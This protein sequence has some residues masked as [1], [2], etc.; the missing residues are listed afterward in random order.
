M[1]LASVMTEL[2]PLITQLDPVGLSKILHELG[3][4]K[5]RGGRDQ[6]ARQN[7][8]LHGFRSLGFLHYLYMDT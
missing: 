4:L 1:N 2:R 6:K 5:K 7:F 3:I 8:L